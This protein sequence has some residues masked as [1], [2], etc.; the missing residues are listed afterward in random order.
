MAALLLYAYLVTA[1]VV[2]APSILTIQVEK[3]I[4]MG[5]FTVFESQIAERA[6][7]DYHLTLQERPTGVILRMVGVGDKKTYFEQPVQNGS[8]AEWTLKPQDPRLA[9]AVKSMGFSITLHATLE[10]K[11]LLKLRLSALP[12]MVLEPNP[13]PMQ[14]TK[15]SKGW[16]SENRKSKVRVVFQRTSIRLSP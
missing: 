10:K 9:D 6:A 16:T 1:W 3:E 15:T 8:S 5:L 7:Q 12:Q 11:S 4:P 13:I 14:W 2:A